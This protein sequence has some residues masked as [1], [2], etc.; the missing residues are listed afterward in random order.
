M[1]R[2]A[3]GRRGRGAAFSGRRPERDHPPRLDAAAADIE[4]VEILRGAV[5]HDVVTAPRREHH[6]LLPQDIP[7]LEEAVQEKAAQ[8]VVIDP[9]MAYLD[10]K[11]N[12][13][14]D[15]HVRATLAPLA[16]VAERT[17]AAILILRHLNKA[18]GMNPI[19]RGGGSIGIVAAAR[20]RLW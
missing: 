18:S 6:F 11:A 19:Q 4:R 13:W 2:R 16:A 12:S 17:G 1:G 9:L 20:A 5:A 15:Q 14:S 7:W 3:S 8:L 10:A